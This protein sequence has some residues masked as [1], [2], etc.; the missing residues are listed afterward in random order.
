MK[1]ELESTDRIVSIVNDR[2]NVPARVW[3]GQ[4][5]DG[6][7]VS[8]LVTRISL[9]ANE[10]DDVIEKFDKELQKTTEP[11]EAAIECWPMRVVL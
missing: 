6:T 8:A 1:I 2:G 5:E 3:E 4:M 7:W 9:K 10:P 11:S